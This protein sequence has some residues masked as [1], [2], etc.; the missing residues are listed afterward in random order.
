VVAPGDRR[1]GID[2]TR[3]GLMRRLAGGSEED[4]YCD[5]NTEIAYQGEQ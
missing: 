1:Q 5:G 2:R 3:P 4:G